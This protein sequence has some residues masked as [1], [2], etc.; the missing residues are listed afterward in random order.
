[1]GIVLSI[2]HC[3]QKP[4]SITHREQQINNPTLNDLR[5]DTQ[6]KVIDELHQMELCANCYINNR[7]EKLILTYLHCQHPWEGVDLPEYLKSLKDEEQ[8]VHS[9]VCEHLSNDFSTMM[10]TMN[11]IKEKLAE[12]CTV[13]FRVISETADCICMTEKDYQI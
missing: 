7:V 13:K 10:G 6:Q 2:A 5:T 3:L 9:I 4:F 11:K 8:H 12:Q 1:M